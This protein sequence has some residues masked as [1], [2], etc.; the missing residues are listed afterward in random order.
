MCRLIR[1]TKR[2]TIS[3][4]PPSLHAPEKSW[5]GIPVR[6][7]SMSCKVTPLSMSSSINFHSGI[8]SRILVDHLISAP[9]SSARVL[10]DTRSPTEIARNSLLLEAIAKTESGVTGDPS[11]R[12]IPYPPNSCLHPVGDVS[13][14]RTT[15]TD[16]PDEF[17]FV[18]KDW[19][20]DSICFEIK[21]SGEF[22]DKGTC[23]AQMKGTSPSTAHNVSVMLGFLN[24][25]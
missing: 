2:R 18:S 7:D 1:D 12:A 20:Y 4:T 8:R 6:C 15:A 17:H 23:S 24:L 21:G 10:F 25:E 19:I 5:R 11:A 14:F 16:S 9:R 13:S 3:D 22:T